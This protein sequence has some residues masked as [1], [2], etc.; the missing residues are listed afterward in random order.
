MFYSFYSINLN[1]NSIVFSKWWC[2]ELLLQQLEYEMKKLEE[3][4]EWNS[5]QIVLKRKIKFLRSQTSF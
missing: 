3:K 1:R 4:I 2:S 5:K